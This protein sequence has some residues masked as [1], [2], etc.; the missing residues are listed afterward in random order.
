M[1]VFLSKVMCRAL[2]HIFD[3]ASLK[4]GITNVVVCSVWQLIL[5]ELGEKLEQLVQDKWGRHVILY[6]LK[7][8]DPQ[9]VNKQIRELLTIGDSNPFSKKDT[10]IRQKELLEQVSVSARL[11]IIGLTSTR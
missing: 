7:P 5:S 10:E 8:R 3:I 11:L 9:N 2:T 6:L 1:K 4:T